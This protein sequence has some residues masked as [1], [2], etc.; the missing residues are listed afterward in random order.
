M[1]R[2]WYPFVTSSQ[3]QTCSVLSM[4]AVT[5]V[6]CCADPPVWHW[7]PQTAAAAPVAAPAGQRR[8]RGCRRC[9][10]GRTWMDARVAQVS[11]QQDGGRQAA[12]VKPSQ[13]QQALQ[14]GHL[15]HQLPNPQDGEVCRL[16]HR[17]AA[18][19]PHT[20][21]PRT[22]CCTPVPA[23]AQQSAS[24]AG[25]GVLQQVQKTKRTEGATQTA[26]QQAGRQW[27]RKPAPVTNWAPPQLHTPAGAP[28]PAR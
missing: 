18:C 1:C 21:R 8:R 27:N 22:S 2:P 26:N 4:P 11:G 13:C 12:A 16:T 19:A 10:G 5:H 24:R 3:P 28:P 15:D 9:R 14:P 6:T 25:S 20:P 7:W 23:A 17:R